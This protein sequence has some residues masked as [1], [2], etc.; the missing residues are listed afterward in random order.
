[1]RILGKEEDL[2]AAMGKLGN[3]QGVET[4]EDT[5]KD[6]SGSTDWERAAH[7]NLLQFW[8]TGPWPSMVHQ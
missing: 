3:G 2:L 1:M 8:K 7:I 4:R 5:R 6:A